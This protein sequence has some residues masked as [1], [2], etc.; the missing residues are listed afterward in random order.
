MRYET[1]LMIRVGAAL[2][3]MLIPVNI[4]HILLTLPTLYLSY[5]PIVL[6]GYKIT[7]T[8]NIIEIGEHTLKFISACTAT[9][10][11]YL[12]AIL[13][14]L[15]K[16]IKFKRGLKIF[17]IGSLLILAMNIIRIDALLIVL[18]ESGVNMFQTLHIIFWEI[19]SS[20]YV[21]AVWI[22][23]VRKYKVKSIPAI[24]DIKELYKKSKLKVKI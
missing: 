19:V 11:Y 7:I 17:I 12:L 9:S 6:M 15:T 16:D 8:G 3:L 21:A 18:M 22:F 1:R 14:L 10:A 24:S 5:L 20:L 13:V 4:F 2:A 23:L